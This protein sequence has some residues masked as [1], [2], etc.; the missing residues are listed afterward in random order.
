M[1]LK[2]ECFN[3]VKIIPK[4]RVSTYKAIANALGSKSYRVIGS[5]LSKNFDK[6]IPCHRVVLSSGKLG[7]FNRGLLSKK[8][9]LKTEGIEIIE[10]KIVNFDEV[11]FDN[12]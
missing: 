10:D 7:G 5:I 2:K 1:V 3:L 12:F 11:F 9:K 4:G 8:K 6:E